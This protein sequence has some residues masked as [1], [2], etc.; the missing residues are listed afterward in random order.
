MVRYAAC[1]MPSWSSTNPFTDP[2]SRLPSNPQ[3]ERQD[4]PSSSTTPR[5][6]IR[7]PLGPFPCALDP[8]FTSNPH[9]S[10]PD[11]PTPA[12]PNGPPATRTPPPS[13]PAA[14][15]ETPTTRSRPAGPSAS[16]PC[17]R[18]PE[19]LFA[20]PSSTCGPT[21]ERRTLLE[22]A[23][24]PRKRRTGRLSASTP[25]TCCFPLY[26]VGSPRDLT[27]LFRRRISWDDGAIRDTS[28]RGEV[29]FLM[30]DC[31]RSGGDG[32]ARAASVGKGWARGGQVPRTCPC[33]VH[34][35]R[36]A[37]LGPQSLPPA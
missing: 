7:R 1:M 21:R 31:C 6:P 35:P 5:S 22:D 34:T 26:L 3:P 28:D 24:R 27:G 23:T 14:P 11:T 32:V 19:P 20:M 12:P 36:R 15:S 33:L 2:I 37:A 13:A 18:M 16:R 25:G 10:P 8:L 30:S 29:A 17:L 4:I 9:G